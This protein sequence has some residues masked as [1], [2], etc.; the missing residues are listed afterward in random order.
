MRRTILA[1]SA[2]MLLFIVV[3]RHSFADSNM[4]FRNDS[5]RTL[6]LYYASA[7]NGATINCV[8]LSYGGSFAPGAMW[9]YSVGANRWGWVR[10][11]EDTW[12]AGCSSS[13]NKFETRIAGSSEGKSE[14]ISVK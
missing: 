2:V 5:G 6:H 8:N 10:F 1:L 7:P 12:N 9:S 13:N 14:T 11:Q 4:T 3:T